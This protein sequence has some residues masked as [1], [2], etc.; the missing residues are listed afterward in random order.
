MQYP[1]AG[2]RVESVLWQEDGR[3]HL[4][5]RHIIILLIRGCQLVIHKEQQAIEKLSAASIDYYCRPSAIVC[6]METKFE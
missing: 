5:K 3:V 6:D 2:S 4:W 1:L